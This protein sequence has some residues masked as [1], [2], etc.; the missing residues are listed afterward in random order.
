MKRFRVTVNGTSYDVEVEE[1]DGELDTGQT[2]A[3]RQSTP[4]A[5]PAR[6]R[7]AH[8]ATQAG[9][10]SSNGAAGSSS[11]SQASATG[12]APAPAQPAPAQPGDAQSGDTQV[13]APMPG[14]VL[15]IQAGAGDSLQAGDVIMVLEA[16]KM[17]NEITAPRA[18][19]IGSIP[20]AEGASVGAGDVLAV[21]T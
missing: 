15:K 8:G 16:M 2:G 9:G 13:K 20:V 1:L 4:A 19:T 5:S 17:E 12:A 11:A 7:G 6:D 21:L 14:T 18:G 3:E 10:T